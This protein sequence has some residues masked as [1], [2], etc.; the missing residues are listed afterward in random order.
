MVKRRVKES[1]EKKKCKKDD[2]GAI[3][4]PGGILLGLGFG[5]VFNNVPAGLF[6]GLGAG[7]VA[8]AITLILRKK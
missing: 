6:I 3:F 8:Y 4:I 2:P 1:L 5:F 7:F